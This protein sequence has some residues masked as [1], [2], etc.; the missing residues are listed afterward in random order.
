MDNEV[1]PTWKLAWGLWWRMFLISLGI[2]VIIGAIM[3]ILF[4]AGVI[5]VPGESF[6]G[7]LP[8]MW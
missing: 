6:F 3:F 4:W 5:C 8:W 2:G 7:W 1:K